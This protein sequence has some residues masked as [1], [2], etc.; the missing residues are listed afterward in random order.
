MIHVR[1]PV[2]N[3]QEMAVATAPAGP[4]VEAGNIA[5]AIE[6]FARAVAGDDYREAFDRNL[7]AGWFDRW[8]AD[9][10]AVFGDSEVQ[11]SF[12]FTSAES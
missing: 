1:R 9:S 5:G 10:G 12:D 7:P 4:L 3:S 8:V 6:V 11:A 2:L